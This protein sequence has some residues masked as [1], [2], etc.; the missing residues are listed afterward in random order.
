L[1]SILKGEI[2]KII[3]TA[4]YKK[5][6]PNIGV[7]DFDPLSSDMDPFGSEAQPEWVIIGKLLNIVREGEID[8]LQKEQIGGISPYDLKAIPE[9]GQ[10][11]HQGDFMRK[12]EDV[13]GGDPMLCEICQRPKRGQSSR[14]KLFVV[15]NLQTGEIK[16][17]GGRCV[18]SL[19]GG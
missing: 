8:V 14:N 6:E 2:M 7:G 16:M 17:V 3:K 15:K 10:E 5:A 19:I 12:V 4:R 13:K 1:G 9:P 11:E 18:P